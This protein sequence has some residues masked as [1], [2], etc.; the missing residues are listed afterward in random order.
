MLNIQQMLEELKAAPYEEIVVRAPHTGR[1]TFAYDTEDPRVSGP[2]GTWKERPGTLLAFIER[3][4]NK[5]P[6]HAHISGEVAQV[7]EAARD[8][9]VQAGQ[10]MLTIRHYLSKEE[11]IEKLLKKA[12]SLFTAPERAKFYFA[13]DVEKKI[14]AS[15]EKSVTV[16]D[17]MDMFIMSRMKREVSLPYSGPEGQIYSVYFHQGDSVNA[18]EPLIG[19]C[20]ADQVALVQDVVARV[21]TEWEEP[22]GA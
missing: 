1:V 5:K 3:E 18:G 22:S 13:P 14:A 21:R 2:S 15:G 9:F 17:G 20:P 6:I 12:L 8:A 10:E 11:V 7:S 19:V 16:T 4:R